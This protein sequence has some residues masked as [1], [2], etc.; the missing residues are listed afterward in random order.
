MDNKVKRISRIENFFSMLLAKAGVSK[1]YFINNLPKEINKDWT[2]MVFVELNV[3]DDKGA[4]T[5]GS[6]TFFLY[7][8]PVGTYNRKDV[9]KMDAMEEALDKAINESNDANYIIR[10]SWRDADYDKDIEFYFNVINVSII[11]K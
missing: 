2:D 1:H 8:K 11:V 6:A 10:T 3:Q 4:Y 7:T 9:K 5:R